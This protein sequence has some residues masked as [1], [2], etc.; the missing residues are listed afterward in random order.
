MGIYGIIRHT[1]TMKGQDKRSPNI[2]D[3]SD[4][5]IERYVLFWFWFWLWTLEGTLRL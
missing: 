5:L 4:A 1:N 3:G 2:M